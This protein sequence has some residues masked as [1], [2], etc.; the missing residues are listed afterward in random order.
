MLGFLYVN[1]FEVCVQDKKVDYFVFG[2]LCV[3]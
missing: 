2:N 1:G 3:E